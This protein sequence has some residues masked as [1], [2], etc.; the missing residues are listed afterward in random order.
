MNGMEWAKEWAK[1]G[2]MSNLLLLL[3]RLAHCIA[4]SSFSFFCISNVKSVDLGEW[5]CE[6]VC[7]ICYLAWTM[8]CS[9]LWLCGREAL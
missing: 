2:S 8:I 5:I 3:D 6:M 7:G 4:S 1:N 9:F